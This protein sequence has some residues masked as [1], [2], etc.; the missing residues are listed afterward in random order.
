MTQVALER[1]PAPPPSEAAAAASFRTRGDRST[2]RRWVSGIPLAF[3]AVFLL[4]PVLAVLDQG[5]RP[6]GRWQLA[7]AL[8]VLTSARTMRLLAFTAWQALLS[9]LLTLIVALPLAYVLARFRFPGREVMRS[10]VIVPFVL[11]TVV[12]GVAFLRL[13]GPNGVL[14]VNLTGSIGAL[15]L[16]HL[17]LNIAVV[18]RTVG[19]VLDQLDP[20]IEDAA[21]L[22]GASRSRA[23]T[24]V[25]LPIVAPALVASAVI[26]FLFCFTSFG[27][28]Q[29]LGSGQLR[30]IEVEI[31]RAT[32][33]DLDLTAA[34]V[35][36][37]LQ[38][39][40]V[41]AVL[42]VVGRLKRGSTHRAVFVASGS[43]ARSARTLGERCLVGGVACTATLLL[44]G[45]LIVL[46][47]G[48]VLGPGGWTSAY[49][50]ALFTPTGS[51][52][53]VDP[54]A[55]IRTSLTTA[56]M[57]TVVALV[58]GAAAVAVLAGRSGGRWLSS[59][60]AML[61]LPL[62]TSAVT[63]GLG[64]FLALDSPPLDLR[65]TWILVPLAQALV[66]VPF[67]VRILLPVVESFDERLVEA[68]T[69]LGASPARARWLV[70]RP[71][72]QPAVVVA[73]GFA[74][75][76]SIGEFGATVF[77]A[78][79]DQPTLP[80]AITRLLGKP[81]ELNLGQAYAASVLMMVLISVIVV[82]ADRV[83][84]TR[85]ASF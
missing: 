28:V 71:V 82:L 65:D 49:W 13:I 35:L 41:V 61:M 23:F 78:R 51:T 21:R 32:T 68:A 30:T 80:V 72:V 31:Y 75:A 57:A 15:L 29:V 9:T 73:A 85:V 3:F 64:L 20:R 58:V 14:G 81:G 84:T 5:L 70:M 12:V 60:D 52:G 6:G 36:A 24:S 47:L 63:V 50:S 83:R 56:V 7:G 48:S 1:S 79:P 77:L 10:L 69:V 42:V 67:V 8:D 44:A 66:A 62:G 16:A 33:F 74:F 26:V 34:A 43:V 46:V 4:V 59:F 53:F 54:M 17:F 39:V 18:V 22:L 11:P 25:T 19:T 2:W 76:V 37:L 38:L 55:A 27:V 40:V 45:P